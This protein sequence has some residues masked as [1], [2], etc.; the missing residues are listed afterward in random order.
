MLT[1][2]VGHSEVADRG[3]VIRIARRGRLFVRRAHGLLGQ[4]I[5]RDVSDVFTVVSV[6][7]PTGQ[8]RVQALG[9]RLHRECQ[10]ANLHARVVVI[11]LARNGIA[12]ALKECANRI[13]QCALPTVPH[14][15]RASGVGRYKLHHHLLPG[16]A[17]ACAKARWCRQHARD[18]RL[19]GCRRQTQ[20]DKARPGNFS[21]GNQVIRRNRRDQRLRQIAR[22]ALQALGHLHRN[23]AGQ[24]PVLGDFGALQCDACCW[25]QV[26][27]FGRGGVQG[28]FQQLGNL[29]FGVQF[30]QFLSGKTLDFTG[31]T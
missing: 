9:A 1:A 4:K 19:L 22:I 29:R 3:D 6:L 14:V 20:I 2:Q 28:G 25:L 31:A 13:A 10:I 8:I 21:R 15:Q 5:A 12:L 26:G 27:A 11:E 30:H 24:V 16:A 23:I 17:L 7:R 18:Y